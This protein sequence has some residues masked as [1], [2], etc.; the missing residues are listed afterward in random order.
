MPAFSS[1]KTIDS[2]LCRKALASS[3]KRMVSAEN[4]CLP[5]I[6]ASGLKVIDVPV[7]RAAPA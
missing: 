7:P 2:P 6:S 3:R 5:K 4:D 1:L